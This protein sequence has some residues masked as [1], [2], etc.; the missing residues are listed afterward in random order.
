MFAHV[1]G[2][3][4][5]MPSTPADFKGMLLA[6]IEDDN[7]VIFIEHRWLHYVSGDVPTGW[8]TTSLDGPRMVHARRPRNH[9]C[10]VVPDAR[11]AARGNRAGAARLRCGRIRSARPPAA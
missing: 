9:R 4:V 11:D 1:P 3:K 2:L 10:H 8:Y 5:V 7:P 6:S